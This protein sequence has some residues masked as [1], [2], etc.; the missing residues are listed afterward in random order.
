MSIYTIDRHNLIIG[1]PLLQEKWRIKMIL[2]FT[3]WQ[4]LPKLNIYQVTF[5]Y[6]TL[7]AHISK[8]KNDSSKQTDF[9]FWIQTSWGYYIVTVGFYL[10]NWHT[11]CKGMHGRTVLFTIVLL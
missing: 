9:R 11:M 3:P 7:E 8:T 4:S 2:L 5:D 1:I 6:K 10:Y